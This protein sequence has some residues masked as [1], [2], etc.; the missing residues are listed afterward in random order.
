MLPSRL[1]SSLRNNRLYIQYKKAKASAALSLYNNPAKDMFVIG[2]T[3]TNGKTTT[4]FLIHHIFNSLVDK[5]FLIGT[6][7]IKFGSE[8]ESNE[9]KMTSPDAS[10]LQSYLALA[11]E[12][13]CKIAVLEVAS[14]GIQQQRFHGIEFDMAVL[15]N[16]TEEHLDYHKTMEDYANTKK[17]LFENVIKNHKPNKLA[18]LP[19][20]DKYGK[21]WIEE[22]HF[23]R[24]M[25]YSILWSG[26]LKAEN[27]QYTF[28]NTSFDINYMGQLYPCT[29]TMVGMHNVYNTL[30]AIGTWLIVWLDLT[31]MIDCLTTFQ[32]PLGRMESLVHNNIRYFIDF[33]HT[34][35]GLEKTLS[36]L[37][38]V[39][40]SGRLLLLTGAM[41]DRDRFKRPLMGKI[42]DQ[43]ADII[44]LA[45]E[46]PGD[47]PR[48]QII[49]EVR[50]GI[51]RI[52]WD[53][54][55]IIPDRSLAIKFIT[56]IAQAGDLVMLAGKGHERVMCIPGGKIP[57]NER[58]ILEGYLG[59][60]KQ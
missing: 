23:D 53:W 26:T 9:S 13:W 43:Y 5:S 45:D 19:K 35:D 15:S 32:A 2:I 40:G 20:D 55:Y 30:A 10:T 22:M 49:Q 34:P 56:E 7:E 59:I 3:G 50:A 44:V 12:K 52:E 51:K 8:S 38:S 28:E 4:S 36:Y 21:K 1:S 6:N 48:L 31:Q 47:E 14:H 27:I 39:K 17:K 54:L 60:K 25:S 57:R 41:G 33:A 46:D 58:E 24:M 42:A 37:H 18:V 16:I 29:I 11:K